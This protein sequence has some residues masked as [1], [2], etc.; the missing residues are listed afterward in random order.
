[1]RET[2]LSPWHWAS[3]I[4]VMTGLYLYNHGWPG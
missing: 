2:K 1:M 4:I 3:I